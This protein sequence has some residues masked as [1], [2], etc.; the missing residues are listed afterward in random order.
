MSSND[1]HPAQEKPGP[2]DQAAE[3][4]GKIRQPQQTD[5]TMT[6]IDRARGAEGD[7]RRRSHGAR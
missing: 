1:K 4:H 3:Q 7:A 6:E 5:A 2:A